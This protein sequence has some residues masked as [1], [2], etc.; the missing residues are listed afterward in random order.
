MMRPMVAV[1]LYTLRDL[2]AEDMVGTLRQVKDI[3]YEGV[4][5]A[6]Y[7]NATPDEVAAT[8][9]E[10]GLHVV[11][12][13]IGFDRLRGD[14][15]SVVQENKSMGN[16]YIVCPSIPGEQRS[17]EGYTAFAKELEKIGRSIGASGMTLCY[18]NH[19]F[20]LQD[21]FEGKM[22]L[23]ILFA[24]SDSGYVQAEIDTYWVQ[25]GGESPSNYIR[26]YAW[27]APLIHIKDMSKDES[28]TFAEVG[29]GSLDWRA[30][31]AAAEEGGAQAYIVEQDVCPG[32]PLDS[33]RTSLQNLKRM[34]KMN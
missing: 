7:G 18:H 27:R 25:K 30:I 9:K 24:S 11:G 17:K 1:Q 10:L 6:G 13:H 12:S 23:D 16:A 21:R 5:L 4:E 15:D 33:I 3:G 29:T 32:D 20:E 28:K 19:D 2:C 14:L 8:L 22:G 26:Q 34:G 31:F